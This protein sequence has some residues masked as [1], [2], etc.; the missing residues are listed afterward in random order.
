MGFFK[1]IG[2][3]LKKVVNIKTLGNVV[4]NTVKGVTKSISLNNLKSAI[5][6]DFKG[7]LKDVTG[8]AV[9]SITGSLKE[10]GGKLFTDT[11]TGMVEVVVD[12]VAVEAAKDTGVQNVVTSVGNSVGNSVVKATLLSYWN[13]YKT[14]FIVGGLAVVSFVAWLIWGRKK[15]SRRGRR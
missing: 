14:W 13:K 7:V 3:S 12:N 10:I 6:G 2:K 5:A 15:T 11:A 9:N 8:K 4:S 1:K